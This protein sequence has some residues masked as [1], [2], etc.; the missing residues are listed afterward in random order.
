MN[1][2]TLMDSI[3]A[4]TKNLSKG[5]CFIKG[6]AEEESISYKDFYGKAIKWLGYLQKKGIKPGNEVVFQIE[7][8]KEFLLA[9]WACLA[10]GFIP[11][12]LTLSYHKEGLSKLEKV[13]NVLEAPTLLTG[14]KA[15]N[16]L[17]EN[18]K[19]IAVDTNKILFTE[20]LEAQKTA[21]K[22]EKITADTTAFIQFSSGSTGTPKGVTL[23]HRNL[24]HNLEGII[25]AAKL[26]PTD[27]MLSWMPL[28]HDMGLIGMHLTPLVVGCNQYI[29]PTELFVRSP[30][31]WIKKIS[32]HAI[33]LT[34][35]PNFGYHHCLGRFNPK[36]VTDLDLSTVRS[37]F[38]G[39]EPISATLC[40]DF[41]TTLAPY[42][43]KDTAMFTVYGLAEASL[44]VTFPEP[45]T[46]V[47]SIKVSRSSLGPGRQIEM[48]EKN[49]LELVNCGKA[50]PHCMIRIAD[51]KGKPV[52]DGEVGFIHIAGINVTSS[53]YNNPEATAGAINKKGWLN[54]GDLGFVYEENL[55]VTGRMKEVI[56]LAGQNVYPHDLER[57]A[58]ELDEIEA[59]KIVACGVPNEEKG[60][61]DVVLFVL[62][63]RKPN[64]FIPLL[65]KLKRHMAASMGIEVAHVVPVRKIPKTTS[66]KI[67]RVEMANEFK[68]GQYSEVTAELNALL[69]AE[70]QDSKKETT[71]VN[72]KEGYAWMKQ[73]LC[74]R[75]GLTMQELDERRPFAELGVTSFIAVEFAREIEARFNI[76]VDPTIAWSYPNLKAL[77]EGIFNS[78]EKEES[79][80]RQ[81]ENPDE[82]IAIVGMACRLPGSASLEA[83]WQMLEGN[84]SGISEASAKRWNKQEIEK[85]APG[86]ITLGG[87]LDHIDTFDADFFG[88][89]PVEATQMDPQQRLLA[90]TAWH[91]MEHAGIPAAKLSQK[92]TGVFIGISSTEYSSLSISNLNV[93]NAYTGIGNAGSIAANRLSYLFNLTGP[94]MAVDTACSS[95]LVAVHQACQ[96]LRL[97]ECEAALA[98]GVNLLINPALNVIFT[99]AG[100][101]SED[102]ACKTFD[103]SAN[104]YVRGEG[105]GVVILKRLSDALKDNDNIHAVIKGSAINQDGKS[106]GLTAP[107]RQAQKAVIRKALA[108]AQVSPE[109]VTYV[110]AHGTGT[111]LGDPIELHAL[112]E[113]LAPGGTDAPH[114]YVGSAKTNIGHLE[115]AA[116]IAGLIKTTL[117][118]K[119]KVIPGLVNFNTL[120]P[121]IQLSKDSRL[122]IA[123]KLEPWKGTGSRAAGVSSFGFGGTNAHM[124]LEEGPV[125]NKAKSRH[126]VYPV[127]ATARTE[128]GLE[129]IAAG[130]SSLQTEDLASLSYSTTCRRTQFAYHKL[131]M[132][133]TTN[134]L[135]AIF[136]ETPACHIAAPKG[137][138]VSLSFGN[139]PAT[140]EIL[141][142]LGDAFEVAGVFIKEHM[143]EGTVY[144]QAY[145]FLYHMAQAIVANQAG[146]TIERVA[147][148]GVGAFTAA[149]LSGAL[150]A[151]E[152]I[153]AINNAETGT[154]PAVSVKPDSSA[155]WVDCQSGEPVNGAE[156]D[157]L[158][159]QY[160]QT[161]ATTAEWADVMVDTPEE[162]GC[163]YRS[164]YH[165]LGT[166]Y[167]KG[168]EVQWDFLF[169]KDQPAYLESLPLYPFERASYWVDNRE[170]SLD[171]LPSV[172]Q[173][174]EDSLLAQHAYVQQWK[175]KGE[176]TAPVFKENVHW[177][178]LAE[179]DDLTESVL[180]ELE[181]N[182]QQYSLL[183]PETET[184]D[185]VCESLHD[186]ARFNKNSE[187]HDYLFLYMWNNAAPVDTCCL[188]ESSYRL[189]ETSNCIEKHFPNGR[190]W[191]VSR[192][193]H[194]AGMITKQ[195]LLQSA[196]W[197][198]GKTIALEAKSIWGGIIDVQETNLP[199]TVSGI[200]SLTL[201]QSD[202]DLILVR[203][204][205]K[206]VYRINRSETVSPTLPVFDEHGHYLVTGGLGYLGIYLCQALVA[207]G[208]R[209][210]TVTSRSKVPSK[211]QWPTLPGS[212]TR[213]QA[214]KSLLALEEQGAVIRV[215]QLDVTSHRDI[216]RLIST[217]RTEGDLKGV[218]HLAGTSEYQSLHDMTLED[219][220]KVVNP[221]TNGSYSL[222]QL[223]EDIPLDHFVC[224][225]SATAVW[226]G[227]SQAHYAAANQFMDTLAHYRKGLGLPALSIN[228]G[229]VLGGGLAQETK[230]VFAKI[231][232]AELEPV[233]LTNSILYLMNSEATQIM[234]AKV[235]W[236]IFKNI[237]ELY[238][239]RP[240]SEDIT[241]ESAASSAPGMHLPDSAFVKE[242][243]ALP[244][245]EREDALADLLEMEVAA[246]LG[247]KKA[248]SRTKGLFDLGM[249]SISALELKERLETKLNV[250]L[251]QTVVFDYPTIND[252]TGLFRDD[253]LSYAFTEEATETEKTNH[254]LQTPAD[255]NLDDMSE[256]ELES[257]LSQQLKNILQ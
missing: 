230:E 219:Y 241:W 46:Q 146:L 23:T 210:I 145:T 184:E 120:N 82:A 212:S 144:P 187:T 201:Q 51:E 50:I 193:S 49:G 200:I 106:N 192:N 108:K 161:P 80:H 171:W 181:R 156:A 119:N 157:L 177:V 17:E 236:D 22:P 33:T 136:D 71:S 3:L 169:E 45:E 227:K 209:H 180:S 91:A 69:E 129:R 94:S 185:Y 128:E 64:Y 55:Y 246:V 124:I 175:D 190:L 67:K 166:L 59:G 44:A 113:V 107:N 40:R 228:L 130:I 88:I 29:M 81:L 122:R 235:N 138:S 117:S 213:K 237:Y 10:G 4:A 41:L 54:T 126:P 42:G 66:G 16:K 72:Q 211:D 173:T 12:P 231:G 28:T 109:Q 18:L 53:Y 199:E 165:Y 141:A 92:E 222:H 148:H 174:Q 233:E 147:G 20:D 24:V 68:D 26:I 27:H 112:D 154:Y 243:M 103:S 115:A 15:Y 133:G 70:I 58:E 204:G 151:S 155:T 93:L 60:L 170:A 118:L 76:A 98:G 252:M 183:Y 160:D 111:P 32:E 251:N 253:L 89:A 86:A 189:I 2:T 215:E 31:I 134:E 79:L 229:P 140:P 186:I 36:Q 110:E 163:I 167:N 114:C 38:N 52:E 85:V 182:G 131:V 150:A 97:G 218:F 61:E 221:K 73:W 220:C 121:H 255:Q 162:S 39:A 105:C 232:I 139:T 43:L 245:H 5:I 25:Q 238:V 127:I 63:K 234:L 35:S 75:L 102:G 216:K 7:D 14:K 159:K 217:M 248:L 191:V 202:E 96:H 239:G 48:D 206:W 164:V 168:F 149:C 13:W 172:D 87:Y 179:K 188:V 197:G 242:L 254:H 1:S 194:Q 56:Y 74:N 223:T 9:F 34:S 47:S 95:S 125:L 257:L 78:A 249:D 158:Q 8:N 83:F 57:V 77:G 256:D 132:A 21:G 142:V 135:A 84:A 143:P 247:Y 207:N 226:G 104:G 214:L 30:V 152:V 250:S 208:A 19:G 153:K 205:R 176:L 195:G 240:L 196:L 100:M 6:A 224:F 65:K 244:V 90:E 62:Y 198:I 203:E 225:S 116:G 37:I 178:I 123:D 101:L 99:K 137:T 11:V